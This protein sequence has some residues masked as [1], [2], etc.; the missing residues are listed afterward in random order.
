MEK[1]RKGK[2]GMTAYVRS[3][4]KCQM[5]VAAALGF[6]IVCAIPAMLSIEG[7][8]L[9]YTNSVA[10]F[11]LWLSVS[12]LMNKIL[13]HE[14][15]GKKG[16]WLIPGIYSFLLSVCMV[17]G[18]NLDLKESI[19]FTSPSMWM[20]ILML[21]IGFT[22]TVR[23]FWDVLQNGKKGEN[24]ALG[25]EQRGF[26]KAASRKQQTVSFFLTAGMI[27]LCYIPVFLAVYPGF[28]VYDAQDELMQVVTRNFSTHHPLVHVLLMGGIIQLVYKI[29]GSYNLGIACYTLFQMTLLSGI[30]SFCICR[31]KKEG[32]QKR[33]RILLTL[34][35]GLWPVIVMF[36]LCSAKDGLFTGMLL[37]M[38]LMLRELFRKPEE[39][40]RKKG[41]VVLLTLSSL[42]M[43]LLR[44]NGFYAFLVFGAVCIL[45]RKLTGLLKYWKRALFLFVGIIVC[46]M[47]M[48]QALTTLF[49]AD[50]SEHQELLT[51]PIQQLARV[52]HDTEESLSEEDKTTLYEILPKEALTRYVPKVSDGVKID[53]NNE[54][55]SQNPGKYLKLWLKWGVQHPFTYLNAWFMTSYGFWYPDTVIDVYR[56]NSVFT[57]TYGDS[58]Y[59]GFEVEQPGERQSKLPLLEECYRR[60]SLEIAQQRIPVI[61]MLFSPGFLFW[62]T[63]FVI[64]FFW[65]VGDYKRLSPYLLPFLIWLTVILG[66]TYLVRYVLFLWILLPLLFW[67]LR[68]LIIKGNCG[69]LTHG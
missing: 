51:V 22:L 8:K 62:V 37:I 44:H 46:Y 53:F 2:K 32:L 45:L 14:F 9:G 57:F 47:V 15:E 24:G 4:A 31:L 55:Y 39:F 68:D 25:E 28:F 61:S 35:F 6:G 18:T 34:Y 67:D 17:L 33:G 11:L 12:F 30:F 29:S 40:W 63:A 27:F 56:G 13:K 1:K 19:A 50:A 21:T 5:A 58:S 65:Y 20:S 64:C 52:Y 3:S 23:F 42:F 41:H 66:P 69:I 10:A 54:V 49:H 60:M 36:S 43:M 16:R 26:L 59:F 7:E 48:N 38:A